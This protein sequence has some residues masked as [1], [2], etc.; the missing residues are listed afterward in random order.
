[1]HLKL[2]FSHDPSDLFRVTAVVTD[3]R[4][5]A[6]VPIVH[7][8]KNEGVFYDLLLKAE[9]DPDTHARLVHAIAAV[10]IAPHSATCCEDVE[11]SSK[12]L[13]ILR[14]ASVLSQNP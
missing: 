5:H 10:V 9:I 8:Y 2:A 12:Q 3:G 14:L 1:M 7:Q 6:P 11:F 13:E 4:N